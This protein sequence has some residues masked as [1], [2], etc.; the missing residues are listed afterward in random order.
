MTRAQEIRAKVLQNNPRFNAAEDAQAVFDWVLGLIDSDD[1]EQ[2]ML[3]GGGIVTI[4]FYTDFPSPRIFS[5]AS[6]LRSSINLS[7]DQL[8]TLFNE[9]KELVNNE[10]GFHAD[11]NTESK[12]NGRP[13]TSL[14]ISI[15]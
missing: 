14:T 3:F 6:A 1:R 9:V 11:L 7:L 10:E 2:K 5:Q 8:Q 4:W 13:A 15:R 12:Q